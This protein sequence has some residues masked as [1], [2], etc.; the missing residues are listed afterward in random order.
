MV[1]HVYVLDS[2][3]PPRALP[4]PTPALA[5]LS[6]LSFAA[7][8]AFLL[9]STLLG[10][11]LLG[12]LVLRHALGAADLFA[13]L[14]LLS[15][16]GKLSIAQGKIVLYSAEAGNGIVPFPQRLGLCVLFLVP[17]TCRITPITA[18]TQ[19]GSFTPRVGRF[20]PQPGVLQLCMLELISRRAQILLKKHRK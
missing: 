1:L 18:P 7:Y 20:I 2:G 4:P 14:H 15:D 16:T 8:I 11:Q 10:S 9:D 6:T 12:C 5:I 3:S 19:L 13:M 17:R